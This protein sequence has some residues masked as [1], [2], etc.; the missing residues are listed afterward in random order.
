MDDAISELSPEITEVRM[1]QGASQAE[2]QGVSPIYKLCSGAKKGS[3]MSCVVS[4]K[5][6][7]ITLYFR[8]SRALKKISEGNVQHLVKLLQPGQS[9]DRRCQTHKEDWAEGG[10]ALIGSYTRS[11]NMIFAFW[12]F[13]DSFIQKASSL[14]G[15]TALGGHEAAHVPEKD[16]PTIP[17]ECL[18]KLLQTDLPNTLNTLRDLLCL[19]KQGQ[20]ENNQKLFKAFL[21]ELHETLKDA[22]CTVDQILSLEDFLE[23]VGDQVGE[24]AEQLVNEILKLADELKVLEPVTG[25]L[26]GL[27]NEPLGNLVTALGGKGKT[28]GGK[29]GG[30]SLPL[31]G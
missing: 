16:V 5:S 19:Y 4:R 8:A 23:K 1:K 24:V 12:T 30:L 15:F 17:K 3:S 7:Y 27:L 29:S 28:Q 26:C 25:L 21:I 18:Q 9:S 20:K 14:N 10:S 31:L 13:F 6:K 22:G 11:C 2:Y